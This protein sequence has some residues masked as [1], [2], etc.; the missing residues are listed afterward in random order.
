MLFDEFMAGT[1]CK[2]NEHNYK[3]YKDLEIMY[4]NS[5]LTKEQIYEYGK[6]LVDNSL[7]EKQLAWNAEIDAQIARLQEQV[8]YY[9]GEVDYYEKAVEL[10]KGYVEE[11]E[12]RKSLR[13]VRNELK[14]WRHQIRTIKTCKYT[15]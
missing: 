14:F 4:M 10:W 9:K 11:K 12:Y 2:D 6:K 8:D 3:V 7:T 5:D 15:A 1:G 13:R